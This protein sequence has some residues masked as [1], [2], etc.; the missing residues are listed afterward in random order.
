MP[1]TVVAATVLGVLALSPESWLDRM[2]TISDYQT[3]PSAMSRIEAWKWAWEFA[4]SHPIFGGG[5]GVFTLDG[6]SITSLG[7]RWNEAHNIFFVMMAQHG[8]VGLGDQIDHAVAD[9]TV[10]GGRRHRNGSNRS[11]DK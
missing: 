2:N 10:R 4:Q 1:F 7:G 9:N 11:L 6:P 5:F 8:F 3:D